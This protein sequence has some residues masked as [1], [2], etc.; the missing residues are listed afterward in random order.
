MNILSALKVYIGSQKKR[1]RVGRGESSGLGKTSGKGNKGQQSR[2]GG[3][4]RPGF[5]GG[6]MP[7]YRKMPK[8][9]GFKSVSN[10]NMAIINLDILEKLGLKT[11]D[12]KVLKDK[13]VISNSSTQVK[14][15][16]DGEITKP[17]TIKVN[18][19]SKQAL[20]KVEK[21]GGKI[22]IVNG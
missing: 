16:S 8:L 18:A 2:S 19:F 6:Q 22:E 17:V 4:K 5:E 3:A 12:L 1:K 11:V 20:A 21:A 14:L 10:D 9:K 15:L 13:K 7:L